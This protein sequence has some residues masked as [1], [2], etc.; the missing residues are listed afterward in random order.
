M[1][2]KKASSRAAK[3]DALS[4]R[5]DPRL[6]YGL[7][8]LSRAQRRSVTGVVEWAIE[9][10]LESEVAHA[11]EGEED[12]TETFADA[13]QLVWSPNELERLAK[14]AS[15]FPEL[16]TYDETRTWAVIKATPQ[17]WV[18]DSEDRRALAPIC[19]DNWDVLEEVLKTAVERSVIKGLTDED[20]KKAG[21]PLTAA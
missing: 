20:L 10:V 18:A 16:L 11:S 4:V 19:L 14:L 1:A 3:T 5:V 7:E 6:R 13:V 21:V 2:T 9:R 15:M 12:T 8:L 17:L